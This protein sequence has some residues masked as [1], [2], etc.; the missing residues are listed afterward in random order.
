MSDGFEQSGY[1][2]ATQG[3]VGEFYAVGFSACNVGEEAHLIRRRFFFSD[4][5][6]FPPLPQAWAL[7]HMGTV[8][9]LV[10]ERFDSF[11][12]SKCSS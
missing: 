12:G 3:L 5:I 9:I 8:S 2:W 1:P 10:L 7:A 4:A 11:V 6:A